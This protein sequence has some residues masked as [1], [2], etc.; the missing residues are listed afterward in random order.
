MN[1]RLSGGI[2]NIM[3]N[4][5]HL[6]RLSPEDISENQPVPYDIYTVAGA[7]L[8]GQGQSASFAEQIPILKFNGWRKAKTDEEM[9]LAKSRREANV[10]D[11]DWLNQAPGPG[12]G[13]DTPLPDDGYRLPSRGRP[14]LDE[15]EVLI[16]EDVR[17]ARRL[18]AHMLSEQGVK[19]V[20]FVENGRD[21][22]HH[23]FH[24]RPH[25]LF[26]DI[27]MPNM[28]GLEVL[29]QIKLWSPDSFAC[30]VSGHGTMAN[31]REAKTFGVNGFLIKPINLINLKRVLA[32]YVKSMETEQ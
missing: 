25:I 8:L 6:V 3:S 27:D 12:G 22:I 19:K 17:L 24:H 29:K 2:F 15:A 20:E 1:C 21:A 14:P 5:L 11:Y 9:A 13:H 26:L 30:M 18:L 32:L 16:A 23:F 31:A 7:L 4:L 10:Q 28:N